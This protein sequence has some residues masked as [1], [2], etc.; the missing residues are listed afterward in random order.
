M[1]AIF[2]SPWN[3]ICSAAKLK[4]D[5][6]F[7]KTHVLGSGPYVFVEHDKGDH[8]AG[9]R[10]DR[11]FLLGKPYLSGYRAEF[12]AGAAAAKGMESGRL[13]GQFRSFSPAE[14]HALTAAYVVTF[15]WWNRILVTS[16]KFK[17]W[18]LTPSQ[19]IGE[20]L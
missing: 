14:R 18:N 19:Y 13:M 3:C 2:A 8:W 15:L 7:P 5:A 16:Q 20:D 4:E 17:G 1:L 6:L 9:K 11:D 12:M 10:W